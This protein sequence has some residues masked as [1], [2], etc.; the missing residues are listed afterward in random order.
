[1]TGSRHA[2]SGLVPTWPIAPINRPERSGCRVDIHSPSNQPVTAS[3]GDF[4]FPA[5]TIRNEN[6]HR[7]NSE[8]TELAPELDVAIAA[9]LRE[10]GY[11]R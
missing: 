11:G 3:A 9:K 6:A 4:P 1:M 7:R 10:L 2:G 8:P 5:S